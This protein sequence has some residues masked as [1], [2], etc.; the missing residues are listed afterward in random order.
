MKKVS[1][2]KDL[3]CE[4]ILE[5]VA[6]ISQL[7]WSDS[8]QFQNLHSFTLHPDNHR[9]MFSIAKQVFRG[10]ALTE[11]QHKLVRTLLVEYYQDQ[12]TKH[13]INLKDHIDQ[14]RFEYRKINSDHWIK[15]QKVKHPKSRQEEQ[16]LV[17]RFPFNKKVIDRI[18]ELKN[19]SDKEYFYDKHK[20]YFPVNEKYVYK[21]VT[22]ARRFRE[23]FEIDNEVMSIYNKLEEFTDHREKYVPGIYNNEIKNLP[24]RAIENIKQDLGEPSDEN[25]YKFYD[26]RKM[27]G[28]VDF[29]QGIVSDNFRHLSVLTKK[30]I[31]RSTTWVSIHPDNYP[32]EMLIDSLIELDRFPLLVVLD[33]RDDSLDKL[34]QLHNRLKLIIP[35]EQ[36][37]VMFRLDSGEEGPNEFNQFVKSA[38]LNNYVDKNT[39]VVY[40]SIN[41]MSKPLFNSGWDPVA[42]FYYSKR[43]IKGNVYNWLEGKDLYLQYTEGLM[44]NFLGRER[45]DHI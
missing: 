41:K 5:L 36:M 43:S 10:V 4:D 45:I 9:L 44:P 17:I 3:T 29:D 7:R 19:E 42:V 11:K 35:T 33:E 28:L 32:L 26:R 6:G 22:I 38:A 24:D 12:F 27:Y 20:H 18:N 23:K 13:S 40:I 31:D 15:I 34:S 2:I 37:S 16:M 14:L 39:K 8:S 1:K 30:I 25:L 21:L